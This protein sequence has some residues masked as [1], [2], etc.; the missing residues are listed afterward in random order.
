MLPPLCHQLTFTAQS[1]TSCE[2]S[3]CSNFLLHRSS[4]RGNQRQ[5]NAVAATSQPESASDTSFCITF[6]FVDVVVVHVSRHRHPPSGFG[7]SRWHPLLRH[8]VIPPF[9]QE[10]IITHN[11]FVKNLTYWHLRHHLIEPVCTVSTQ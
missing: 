10:Q 5:R 7:E 8:G 6:R 4:F 9:I 3:R 1:H 11:H 2:K